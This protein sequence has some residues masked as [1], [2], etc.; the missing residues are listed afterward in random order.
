MLQAD[1][2]VSGREE[3]QHTYSSLLVQLDEVLP[4]L[5]SMLRR[6]RLY[7]RLEARRGM[8]D[9]RAASQGQYAD[10]EAIDAA[11]PTAPWEAADQADALELLGLLRTLFLLPVQW[12][13]WTRC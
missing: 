13:C 3:A 7:A 2:A 11:E 12:L 9:M 10:W 6:T 1:T 4:I 8:Q 5:R